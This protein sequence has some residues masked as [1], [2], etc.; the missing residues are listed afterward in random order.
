MKIWNDKLALKW[1]QVSPAM[2]P[3]ADVAT[4]ELPLGRLLRLSLFQV[5]VAMAVV[6]LNGTLNR[7][8]IV[9]LGVPSAVV[10]LMISLPLLFAPFRALIGFRSDNHRTAL[11]WRRA[12]F[13]W[14]GSLLQ[15]GGLAIM[16]FAIILLSGDSIGPAW[17]GVTGAALAFLLVGIGL[18]TTQTA[19]LAL[20]TD[21]ASAS[22]RPRV[23]AF[24]YVMLL[25]G[26]VVSS[27]AF[28]AL[29][30][31]FSQLRLIQVVQGAAVVTIVL[32]VIALW[33]QE[34]RGR[35]PALAD[36]E[37]SDF[38]AAWH[39]YAEAPGARRTLIAI[40]FGTAAF[41]MQ[42]ILLEP[43]GG[44]VLGF[45]VGETTALTGMLAAGTLAG[46]AVAAN[47][48]TRGNDTYR[49][50]ALG[51]LVG[52]IAFPA[53]LLAGATD[54]GLLFRIGT[55]L[56]GFG[57]GLFS[58]GSLTA[59]MAI[60]TRGGNG[61]ALGAWGAVTATAA[62]LAIAFSGAIRDTVSVLA[63]AGDLGVA[64][65]SAAAGY[66]VVYLIELML[67]FATLVAI[68]PLV[69]RGRLERRH[70]TTRFGIAEFPG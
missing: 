59:A 24:L 62:G 49:I 6:L 22:N 12:P 16:P 37:A 13:I 64:F 54:S 2:L 43:Y 3:F 40:G 41:S 30:S 18:H 23:V 51:V 65:Q 5:S 48:L 4:T 26:T 34:A 38:F 55:V 15:F 56:I 67:L 70:A 31:A 7:V 50:A 61:M 53:V 28:G 47:Q 21:I 46:F 20:A 29:L 45:T 63:H 8:M 9:E 19:G 66:N 35:L 58:V 69:G 27:L 10:G 32:N 52:L 42:D 14:F 1:L 25:I 60:A 57:T 11:G 44:E 68:G 33:K 17:V 36:G 39:D